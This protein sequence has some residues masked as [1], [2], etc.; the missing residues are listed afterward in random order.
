[1]PAGEDGDR[2]GAPADDRP[3]IRIRDRDRDRDHDRDH[4]R[5][6]EEVTT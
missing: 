3:R 4:D 1:V 2:G 5:V 6:G